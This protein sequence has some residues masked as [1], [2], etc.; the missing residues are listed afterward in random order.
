MVATIEYPFYVYHL[1][2]ELS[3]LAKKKGT[4]KFE[5]KWRP[6]L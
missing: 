2:S 4:E 5:L 6:E 1:Q 3:A